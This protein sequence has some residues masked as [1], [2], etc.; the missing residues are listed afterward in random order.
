MAPALSILACGLLWL[1]AVA[2]EQLPLGTKLN[3]DGSNDYH[4]F[5]HPIKKVAIIGAGAN[6]LQQA[7]V[8]L[9]HGFE[10]RLFERAPLPGGVWLYSDKSTV[11]VS[12]P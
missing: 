1:S 9:E 10:V 7:A 8:L 12:F 3:K 5:E 2:A 4:V 11:P 6:G